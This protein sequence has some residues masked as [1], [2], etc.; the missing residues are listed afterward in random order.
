[1]KQ[2]LL[3]FI[4]LNVFV[5]S[6]AVNHWETVVYENDTWKYLVPTS[7]VSSSW[8]QLAYNDAGWNIGPG[9]FGYGDGDDNTTFGSALS[10]FQRITFN[11][12]DINAIDQVVLNIDYDDAFVAYLNG[13]EIG[14]DNIT[15]SG[16]PAYNQAS[17]GLHEAQMYS[18]G[19]P[20]QL[21]FSAASLVNGMNVLC[22]QVHNESLGSS[23]MSSRVWLSLGINNSSNDY[24]ATPGWF[25]PPFDFVSSNLPIVVI[26]TAGGATIPNEPKIDAS[27][28]IIYNGVGVRNYLSDPFSEYSG[29]IGIEVR[30]SSSQMFPKKQWGFETRDNF[31]IRNDV[32]LFNMAYDND[33]ILY[34]PYSDKS[35]IRNVMAYEMGK[36]LG[37]YA[38][39]T[40]L[41]EVVLNGDYHGVYVL[42]EKI[43]RKD[44]KVGSNDVDQQ[45]VSGNEL[46]GDY[47]IKVDKTTA[48]GVVAW[49]SPYPPYSG[50]SQ[51]TTFQLH[52]P[53]IDSL[54]SIQQ[55]YIENY[56]TNFES[57]LNGPN[58][59]DPVLGFAP[60]ID[61][62]SFVDFLLVNEASHNVDGYR[63][64]SYLHKIRT[65]EGGK[66]F[67]GPLWDFNLAFGNA[68]YCSGSSTS[69]WEMNFYQV[70]GNDN[71]QNP[72][73]WKKLTQ[74]VNFNHELNC[75]WQRMRQGAWHTDSLMARVDTLAA[76]LD[77]AQQRNFQRWQILGS[78]V[79]PNDFIGNTYAEEISYIKTWITDR[80]NWLDGNMFG[81][82]TDLGISEKMSS[83]I[84]VYPNPGN[85]DFH[86]TLGIAAANAELN[87]LD[88]DGKVVYS[89]YGISGKGHD[90]HVDNLAPG[91]YH[92]I[93]KIQGKVVTG[94][95]MIQ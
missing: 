34:A 80:M 14:R 1:M 93:I 73:W 2:L 6:S 75:K 4:L 40:K 83:A 20:N 24:G 33:W 17:D 68:N 30:G 71:W 59:A 90:I 5:V 37:G 95:L 88:I 60:Y 61:I 89:E 28:G 82:C 55:N 22:V 46:T 35:L 16:Q 52:D 7:V 36:D 10:C 74:D 45:D 67:A 38:P 77:E 84:S 32:T 9:G 92:Y 62:N 85:E 63:I 87:L 44:G 29:N 81:S 12:V 56:V 53:P 27:M 57:A 23:D 13:V 50:A 18:G 94:K 49:S 8:N 43:K 11:I 42:T 41:C 79:W 25:N 39:R 15:S 76:Y 64:S 51:N 48:G 72:F 91:L 26:N 58:F 19:A 66:L 65:S 86:F 21:I 47:V 69:G 70:C 54:N 78:Y 31:G 3:S